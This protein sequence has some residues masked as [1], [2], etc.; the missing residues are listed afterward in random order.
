MNNKKIIDIAKIMLILIWMAVVFGFSNEN[1]GKSTSTS[2]KVTTT[3]VQAVSNK[4]EEEKEKII[5][6]ADK[7]VRKIAHYTIYTIG[8]ALIINYAYTTDKKMKTKI[9]GSIAFG[10]SYAMAD[11]IHQFFVSERSARIFDVGIDTLGVITGICIYLLIRKI[12]NKL[13]TRQKESTIT[14]K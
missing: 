13:K 5:E 10:G 4:S 1:G 2:R 6:K 7:I 9:I 14:D 12:I 8:G 11:E 3:V